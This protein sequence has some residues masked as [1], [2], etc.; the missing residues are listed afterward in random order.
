VPFTTERAIEDVAANIF[1][2]L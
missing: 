2:V 1:N